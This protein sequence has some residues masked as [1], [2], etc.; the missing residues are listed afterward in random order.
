[1]KIIDL[2]P[3][4]KEDVVT[5][6]KNEI[7]ILTKLRECKCVVHLYAHEHRD[8][9]KKL[10][11]L[12]E[13]GNPDLKVVLNPFVADDNEPKQHTPQA[14]KSYFKGMVEAIDEIHRLKVVHADLKPDNFILVNEK[15]KLIDFGVSSAN[16]ENL[17]DNYDYMSPE[18][19]TLRTGPIYKDKEKRKMAIKSYY[20]TDI[21][22]L[23]CILYDMASGHAPFQICRDK[24]KAIFNPSHKIDYSKIQ[25]QQLVDC[26]KKCLQ[27]DQ[28]KRPTASELL[29]H[30]YL[31]N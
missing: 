30:P 2:E 25:N 11:M 20:K 24:M 8:S 1:L 26:I 27:H 13:K 4:E 6:Y 18:I 14:I 29:R 12:I 3:N 7:D 19:L 21:W 23:G 17:I 5:S 31:A 28:T 9:E 22:S 15:V 10:L 16:L